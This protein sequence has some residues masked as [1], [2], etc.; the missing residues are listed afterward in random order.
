M[1]MVYC[2]GVSWG[3]S[4]SPL[5]EVFLEYSVRASLKRDMRLL[6]RGFPS[7]CICIFNHTVSWLSYNI[8]M[9]HSRS[10]TVCRMSKRA[11]AAVGSCGLRKAG[12]GIAC[13]PTAT[14]TYD[15]SKAASMNCKPS[16][17]TWMIKVPSFSNCEICSTPNPLLSLPTGGRCGRGTYK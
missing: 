10:R 6:A 2:P 1:V 9:R 8:L 7:F 17:A 12:A 16:V 5:F 11:A 4:T 15:G 14:S 3:N 13:P